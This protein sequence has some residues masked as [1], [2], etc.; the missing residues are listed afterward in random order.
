MDLMR[1]RVNLIRE[2]ASLL[3]SIADSPASQFRRCEQADAR[4]IGT[5]Q[6]ERRLRQLLQHVLGVLCQLGCEHR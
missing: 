2:T 4:R 6:I 3:A 5:A 1:H